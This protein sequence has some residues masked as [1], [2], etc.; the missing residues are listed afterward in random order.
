[1]R[2]PLFLTVMIL[3]SA[4]SY[5]E[6]KFKPT[7]DCGSANVTAGDTCSNVKVEFNFN[8]CS[9]NSQPQ[10]AQKILCEGT[11]IKARYE[12]DGYR[13][14]A[15]FNKKDG[16]WGSG[17]TW[18]SVGQMKEY[19][20]EK[21]NKHSEAKA[22]QKSE[23][24]PAAK[25]DAKPAERTPGAAPS[26]APAVTPQTPV[27]ASPAPAAAPASTAPASATAAAPASPLKFS[28]FFDFRYS[29]FSAPQ[30]PNVVDAHSESGFGLEDAAFYMN[31]EKDRVSFVMDLAFRR[32]KTYD[33]NPTVAPPHNESNFSTFALGV[34]K[35]QLYLRYKVL[36]SLIFDFGQ[37]DTVYGVEVN[38][39]K[40][41]VFGK[42]GLVYD[43]TLPVT[44]TGFMAE[45]ANNGFS[46]KAL[47]ANPNNK[48]SNGTSPT[49][50]TN[51]EYGVA[52]GYSNEVIRGQLGYM[53][54]PIATADGTG[55]ASR[56]LVDVT[57]GTTLGR[58]SL[59]LEYS[60]VSD[61]SKNTLTPTD[62]T[63]TEKAGTGLLAL[64]TVKIA[65]PFLLGL[66]Y[67]I[68]NDDPSSMSLSHADA[69]G[70]SLHYKLS[71]DLELR[72]EYIGYNYQNV[73][74]T[75]WSDARFN[76]AALV[77]F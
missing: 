40:D 54:R 69:L 36:D 4:R 6:A 62:N 38:D 75:K 19:E 65:E 45:Y 53:A 27:A 16:G 72:S 77:L 50:D 18:E 46:V 12:I 31:Y 68:I 64:A 25:V 24:H 8:G 26:T 76:V 5:S 23:T 60:M 55:M 61:P 34:D 14:E 20:K 29:T 22:T 17:V 41:R 39:S 1:M 37:F 56:S 11:Q 10:P 59:D 57:A 32:G 13:Y 70:L 47:A 28:G 51:T 35:S 44:H 21:K 58:Y 67:E 15:L 7:K 30:D 49:Q 43:L 73:A 63:D 74:G 52:A 71:S 9:V 2:K 66:R 48:G 42:T 3:T 33:L